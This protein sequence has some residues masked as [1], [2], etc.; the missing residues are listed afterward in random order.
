MHVWEI[1][2][3]S[4]VIRGLEIGMGKCFLDLVY[5]GLVAS[6]C[7]MFVVLARYWAVSCSDGLAQLVGRCPWVLEE[8]GKHPLTNL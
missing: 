3:I 1:T 7:K 8:A 6:G 2:Y 4:L 5:T